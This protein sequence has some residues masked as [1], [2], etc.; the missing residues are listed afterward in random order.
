MY[1]KKINNTKIFI[2]IL[3][4]VFICTQLG[5][6]SIVNAFPSSDAE[7]IY[8]ESDKVD[9]AKLESEIED[10]YNKRSSVLV[11]GNLSD[12]PGCFDTSQKYG[13]WAL[14]HEVKRAKYLKDWSN[15]RGLKFTDIKSTVRVKKAYPTKRGVRVGLEESYKFDYIYEKDENPITNSF[16]VGIRHT[17]DLIKKDNG[18]LIYN[19]WYTDCFEDA[20]LA[21]SGDV[22]TIETKGCIYDF[23][24][25]QKP[26]D[27][28]VSTGKYNRL[29]AVE[30]ADKYCGAAWGSEND[31]KYN[32]KYKDF[33]GIGGDC[34][35]FA[36][37][38]LGDKEAGGLKFDGTWHCSY[39]KYGN[40]TGSSAWV[41]ADALRSY[42]V[43]SGKGSLIKKGT[44]KDLVTPTNDYAC[45][46][47]QKLQLG[48][49]VCY[50][51][52]SNMDHFGIVTGWDSHGYPLINSH[53]TD[54][55]HVPWDLGWGDKNIFF[56]LI[57]II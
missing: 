49:L 50:A 39:S 8:T 41:N 29:K 46:F 48:D 5:L 36:S 31:F 15:Q 9:N 22:T 21:Y 44:F 16:G 11:T 24:N 57:H 12:L 1:F 47:V 20:L 13:K 27:P 17:L 26:S 7:C 30:Y 23:T 51:K 32:K 40:S 10:I 3:F 42:L 38:I 35:N 25:C 37:Q 34:T 56:H 45:G 28:T 19:D 4:I 43:Y 33:T 6:S 18:Y 14:E 55:Y 53:T 52:K 2:L 54:R